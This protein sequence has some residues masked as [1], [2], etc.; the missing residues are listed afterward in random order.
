MQVNRGSMATIAALAAS[1]WTGAAN[2]AE[3]KVTLL[4]TGTPTPRLGSFSAST[5]VEAGP[6]KLIFDFGR[7]S[8]IRLFQKKIALGSITA[9]FITHLHSDHVIGLPDMWL[10][11]WVGTP[12]LRAP[13]RCWFSDLKVPWP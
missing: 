2:A 5:L 9:H 6:E 7:G 4:C 11:G 13:D 10:T 3:I 8:T 1:F 12:G